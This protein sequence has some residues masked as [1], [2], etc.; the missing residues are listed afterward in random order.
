MGKRKISQDMKECALRLW[1]EG[2]D[3]HDICGTLDVSRASL[4]R[5]REV[6]DSFGDIVRPP[7]PLVGRKRL[8]TR[9]AVEGM[10]ALL[11]AHPDTYLDELVWWLELH[12]NIVVAPSTLHSYLT[13]VGLTHKRLQKLAAERD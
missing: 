3:E 8:I 4:Y 9:A 7:S 13:E 10:R 2:W 11:H 1:E 6:F 12:H 5:W